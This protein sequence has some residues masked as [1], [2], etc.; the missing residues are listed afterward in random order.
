MSPFLTHCD[1]IFVP[2]SVG[3]A[4]VFA[5][6]HYLDE[7]KT[8]FNRQKSNLEGP[9][10]PIVL[11]PNMV[12]SRDE[13]NELRN[14]FSSHGVFFGKPLY[15]APIFRRAFRSDEND[16]S[17]A[18]LLRQAKPYIGWLTKLIRKANELPPSTKKLFQL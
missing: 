11:L 1:A 17:V 10:P 6:L 9:P 5:T 18:K 8:L 16:T 12:D 13:F 15:Y 2:T 14:H 4:D 7:L 3:D